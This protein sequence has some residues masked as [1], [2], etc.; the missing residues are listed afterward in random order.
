MT[1]PRFPV[2]TD[3]KTLIDVSGF[4]QAL[5]KSSGTGVGGNINIDFV[6]S[7]VTD[8]DADGSTVLMERNQGY[9]AYICRTAA[10]GLNLPIVI[11]VNH[12]KGLQAPAFTTNPYKL[13]VVNEMVV[14]YFQ[15][16]NDQN[17]IR[18]RCN[19]MNVADEIKVSLMK[20]C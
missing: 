12:A 14:Y 17:T 16:D 1:R 5:T 2:D 9:V 7:D 3:G 10:P 8:A 18:F 13:D 20:L 6:A 19:A 15:T 4:R 11:N